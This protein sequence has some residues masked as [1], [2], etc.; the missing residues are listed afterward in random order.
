M[1]E[2]VKVWQR[3]KGETALP[4]IDGL[5]GL[6]AGSLSR[7][8]YYS[9]L[10]RQM[11]GPARAILI[12]MQEEEQHCARC[13]KG[14]YRMIT[15]NVLKPTAVPFT[16]ENTEAGLRKCYSQ[17]LKAMFACNARISD[18][19][20]GAVFTFLSEKMG[21]HCCALTELMGF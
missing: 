13:M 9:T 1:E 21:Q 4:P 17:T 7:A 16:S 10:A 12:A 19:E 14:I 2:H 8:A 20:Y 3:V 11:Q 18:S 6:V 5:P 15:G